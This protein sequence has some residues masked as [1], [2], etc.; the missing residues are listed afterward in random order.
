MAASVEHVFAQIQRWTS[1]RLAQSSDAVLLERFVQRRDEAAFAALVA[2]HGAMVLRSC[3]RVLGDVPE[4]EDAFQATFLILARKAHKLRRPEA[5]PGFLHSVARRVALKARSNSA[6]R[7]S[8]TPLPEVPS[9]P[10]TDP[11]AQLTARELLTILDEE[12]QRLPSAQRSAVV[13][14]CLEGHTQEEA[15]RILG[16]TA[17]SLKGHLERGRKRLHARLIRRGIALP[18]ALAIVAVS[19]GE[20]ASALLQQSAVRAALGGA[21]GSPIAALA[22]SV[23]KGLSAAKLA[24]MMAVVLT[25]ALSVSAVAMVYR[26][27]AA[28]SP[29]DKPP[30]APAA[31]QRAE[32][33]KPA[34]RVDAQGDPLPAGAI[35]RL[36][37]VRFRHGQQI[38]F[39]AFTPDGKRLLSQGG[40]GVRVWDAATG[41]ELRHFAP[42]GG[43][44]WQVGSDLSPDGKQLAVSTSLDVAPDD[45]IEF[46]DVDSG[47]K[48]GALGERLSL[49]VRFSPDGKLLVAVSQFMTVDIWDIASRK[50]LRSWQAHAKMAFPVVFSMDSRKLL[51]RGLAGEVRLWDVA[52]GRKL[53]EFKPL[54]WKEGEGRYY[55][56][57][58]NALSPDGSLLAMIEPNEKQKSAAGKIEWKT[59]ISLWDTTTGKPTRV[60]SYPAYE[61]V[62]GQ[63]LPLRGVAFTPDGKALLTAGPDRSIHLW[64]PDTGKELRRLSLDGFPISLA[65]SQDGKKLAVPV[66]GME[67][68]TA[69]RVLD[70]KSGQ[71]TTPPGGHL[72]RVM[73]AALTPDGRT[74][75]TGNPLEPLYVWDATAGRVRQR[76][77]GHN[78]LVLTLQLSEDGRT[79]FTSGLDKTLRIWDLATGKERRRITLEGGFAR[80]GFGE[81]TLT[82]DG[83]TLAVMDGSK[84]IRIFEVGGGERQHFPGPERL[85]GMGLTPDGRS[86]LAWSADYKVGVWDTATGRK[87]HEYPLPRAD[88]RMGL[89]EE[90][91]NACLSRDGR[92]LAVG[93]RTHS[94]GDRR[95]PGFLILK[96]LA[97]GHV[98]HRIDNL[99]SETAL[100]AFS[101]DGRMLAWGGYEDP[102][103]RLLEVAS[104]RE[105]RRLT[106]HRGQITALAF[107]A[108]GRRLLSG[109][110]DTTA[111]VWDLAGHSPATLTA[112]ELD[113][114][115]ADLAGADAAR[116]Y[117]AMHQLA[118]APDSSVLFLRKRLQPVATVDEKRMARLIA[119][120]DS[121]D[122]PVRQ[123]ATAALGELA[124]QPLAA[125]RKAL[126]GK[127]SLETR[128]RLEDLLE[129]ASSAWWDVSGERLRSLRAVETLERAG[130]KEA[131]EVLTLLAAGAPAARLSEQAK[132]ALRQLASQERNGSP[133]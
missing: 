27:P 25:V 52:T 21:G 118:S 63:A 44:T 115:W 131:R 51:T 31:P 94:R 13:L 4:A 109:C 95:P 20:A 59:R 87:L 76:L 106:G 104:G 84:T 113:A 17:G 53:Q 50:K 18:A 35:A 60:L 119:D 55:L 107:A 29:E 36:G 48:V 89:P 74:A 34:K 10:R 57:M 99:S 6:V 42:E 117:R 23:L 62:P 67:G 90:H 40:D 49:P 24:G 110:N 58:T 66:M 78:G 114:L 14:C 8:Q 68:N 124:D 30:A 70:L 127:P 88:E 128:R 81:L 77:E 9:D 28:M 129:K 11:L 32:A 112:A 82:P 73:W 80:S 130:T 85:L 19:R 43:R 83:K 102:A 37:T 108:D 105:R 22:E 86:L 122:L 2:Q 12:V 15:A 132:A 75:V 116:A 46:W 5:L 41:K 125:Y 47:K 120:L 111:L 97:T 121:E 26:T 64:E 103:I 33:G 1:S 69:I 98:V 79:L 100:V 133:R 7:F 93:P 61:F 54:G 39:L 71:P 96:D 123:K 65:L 91:Y 72:I 38:M 101:P 92:L 3:R 126:E 16:W 45:A 56:P